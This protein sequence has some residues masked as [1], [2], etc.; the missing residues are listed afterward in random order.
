[1]D[2]PRYKILD[3]GCGPTKREHS[4]GIDKVASSAADV[5]H[6]LNQ[7]P[8]PFSDNSF[9]K[10]F[11][12]NVIEHLD[13]VIKVMIELHRIAMPDAVVSITVPFFAHRNAF[14]DPTHKHFFGIHSFDYF[15]KGTSHEQFHY[16]G[17]HYRLMSVEFNKGL[18]TR[19]WFDRFIVRFANRNK[20]LY[21]NRFANI[22][23]LPQLTFAL[24]VVKP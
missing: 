2:N 1:L 14:T 19:H 7:F 20:D 13:D 23:P 21:E 3:V 6:D 10:I 17:V 9:E 22:F 15:F 5:L 24:K 18:H 16:A 8:Y 11:A 4:I 12:D